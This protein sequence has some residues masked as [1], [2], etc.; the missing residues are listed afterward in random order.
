MTDLVNLPLDATT[1]S[2]KN[3]SPANWNQPQSPFRLE[4][5]LNRFNPN[6]LAQ[7]QV[8][9]RLA[10]LEIPGIVRQQEAH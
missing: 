1:S 4:L 9:H 10:I 3:M 6:G 5:T 7:S 2:A 8:L